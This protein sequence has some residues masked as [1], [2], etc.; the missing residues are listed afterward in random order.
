MMVGVMFCEEKVGR[1]HQSACDVFRR[2]FGE[3]N[4]VIAVDQKLSD[5]ARQ[6]CA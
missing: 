4:K 3:E 1:F 6:T 2:L 5:V